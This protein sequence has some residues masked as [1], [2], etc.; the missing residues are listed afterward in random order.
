MV[1]RLQNLN[2][3]GNV[4]KH[5]VALVHAAG[6]E[7]LALALLPLA[8]AAERLLATRLLRQ[9]Q[10]LDG[11]ALARLHV[12][13]GF[14]NRVAACA[15]E[16]LGAARGRHDS[17]VAARALQQARASTGDARRREARQGAFWR[18]ALCSPGRPRVARRWEP[19]ARSVTRSPMLVQAGP[20][21][22]RTQRAAER[23][24]VRYASWGSAALHGGANS[25]LAGLCA[26]LLRRHSGLL[27][28]LCLGGRTAA[29]AQTRRHALSR[30]TACFSSTKGLK[31]Q[32][33]ANALRR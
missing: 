10:D 32:C 12:C 19:C 13:R 6:V 17:D 30:A 7:A 1:Q 24:V 14:D 16:T 2:L 5:E 26:R 3:V 25:V 21:A 18:K 28:R 20:T 11:N 9:L 27:L 29:A 33:R 31:Q 23:V 22:P 15:C 4:V 8:H